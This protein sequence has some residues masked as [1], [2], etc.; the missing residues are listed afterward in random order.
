MEHSVTAPSTTFDMIE[1]Q[2]LRQEVLLRILVQNLILL[3]LMPMLL[4]TI[5]MMTVQPAAALLAALGYG[6]AT[7]VGALIWCH[8]GVRQAQLKTYL[9]VLEERYAAKE[10]WESWL[11]VHRLGGT[12]G[13]RWFISTKGVFLGS[14]LSA[15]AVGLWVVPT[16]PIGLLLLVCA[17]ITCT[18]YFLLSNPKEGLAAV[19]KHRP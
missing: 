19:N 1:L 3:M 2:S 5:W 6:L 17:V 7:G 13:S 11:P 8:C 18:A 12:L 16:R 9:L 15:L 14:Q 10:G 4:A